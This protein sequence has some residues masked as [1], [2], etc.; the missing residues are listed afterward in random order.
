MLIRFRNTSPQASKLWL[1]VSTMVPFTLSTADEQDEEY[2][3]LTIN[4]QVPDLIIYEQPGNGVMLDLLL[5][6]GHDQ[7]PDHI[8]GG[9]EEHPLPLRQNH[10]LGENPHRVT[11]LRGTG[12]KKLLMRRMEGVRTR[13]CRVETP[14][15]LS[16][17][18]A[19]GVA[20]NTEMPGELPNGDP[21]LPMPLADLFPTLPSNDSTLLS[22]AGLRSY[23]PTLFFPSIR[24]LCRRRSTLR[25][26]NGYLVEPA[27]SSSTI[28]SKNPS[29]NHLTLTVYEFPS[30]THPIPMPLAVKR[31]EHIVLYLGSGVIHQEIPCILDVV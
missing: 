2:R 30:H 3:P 17:R 27:I 24:G 21:L 20:V 9:S 19:Y 10:L 13:G 5:G 12:T 7:C 15:L 11:D 8:R 26:G 6:K 25:R 23:E 4:G 31:N 16:K 28:V 1:S 29:F 14:L 22:P 18:M